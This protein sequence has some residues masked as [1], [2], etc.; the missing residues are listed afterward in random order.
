MNYDIL[1]QDMYMYDVYKE[2]INKVQH[3]ALNGNMQSLSIRYYKN[4]ILYSKGYVDQIDY[5][6]P[7]DYKRSF[8]IFDF[9]PVLEMQPLNYTS[10]DL[11][12]NQGVIRRTNGVLTLMGVPNPLPGDIFHFYQNETNIEY[13]KVL[14]VNYIKSVNSVNIYQIEFETY[15]VKSETVDRFDIINHYYYIKEFFKFFD[16]QI[17]ETYSFL[18]ENR[19][20]ILNDISTY[21][22]VVKCEYNE[23]IKSS[24]GSLLYLSPEVKSKLNSVLL[25]LNKLIRLNIKV[26]LKHE[27]IWHG[28]TSNVCESLTEDDMHV[29]D[30]TIDPNL[31]LYGGEPFVPYHNYQKS[32]L[33]YLIKTLQ[34]KYM[35]FIMYEPTIDDTEGSQQGVKENIEIID[36]AS[37]LHKSTSENNTISEQ[38]IYD[39]DKNIIGVNNE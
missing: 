22:D 18:I 17:Y 5:Y 24:D 21:Y 35:E 9:S 6:G 29:L 8:D 26:I 11:D 23:T 25:Y 19:N 13:F 38:L 14:R 36:R 10:D 20:K 1:H 3:Y 37:S 15:N 2:Y 16:S 32:N 31:D 39:L 34:D 12:E 33:V 28:I 4:N 30:P 7:S 27:I